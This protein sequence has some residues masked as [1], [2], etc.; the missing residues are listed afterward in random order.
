MLTDNQYRCGYC[1]HVFEKEISDEEALE[2]KN[3][4]FRNLSLEDMVIVCDHCFIDLGFS[5]E[6]FH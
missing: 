2:E 4:L 5:P 6:G 1:M 3:R